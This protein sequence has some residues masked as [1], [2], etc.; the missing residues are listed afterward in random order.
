MTAWIDSAF[1]SCPVTLRSTSG[2]VIAL[3]SSAVLWRSLT[4]D[5]D[6]T[7]TSAMEAEFWGIFEGLEEILRIRAILAFMGF[8]QPPTTGG[9]GASTATVYF[10]F[11][12]QLR[13]SGLPAD[14][15]VG[16]LKKD[17]SFALRRG[18]IAQVTTALD[19][20]QRALV[21]RG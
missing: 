1:A 5:T 21:R 8:P 17:I 16:K 3:G 7:T 6:A 15:L 2:M 20:A 13:D 10:L 14:T 9:H 11:A 4:Q 19:A 18:T 12:K